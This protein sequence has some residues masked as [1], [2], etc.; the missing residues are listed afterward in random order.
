MPNLSVTTKTEFLK[1]KSEF[2]KLGWFKR[3]FFPG[4]LATS[5]NF[6][7]T[8]IETTE[9]GWHIWKTFQKPSWFQKWLFPFLDDFANNSL[10]SNLEKLKRLGKLSQDYFEVA[11]Q[12]SNP[13]TTVEALIYLEEQDLLSIYKRSAQTLRYTEANVKAKLMLIAQANEPLKIAN[14]FNKLYRSSI[15][16]FTGSDKEDNKKLLLGNDDNDCIVVAE[17]KFPEL[18]ASGLF[19]LYSNSLL[20][21]ENEI[22]SI[23]NREVI[24]NS[25]RPD[26]AANALVALKKATLLTGDNAQVNRNAVA[27]HVNPQDLANALIHLNKTNLLNDSN[28]DAVTAHAF[29]EEV[30]KGLCEFEKEGLLATDQAQDYR[31]LLVKQKSPNRIASALVILIKAGLASDNY[32][33]AVAKHDDCWSAAIT[34]KDLGKANLLIGEDAQANLNA[35][36]PRKTCYGVVWGL[37]LLNKANLLTG[38]NAQRFR[39]AISAH[40]SPADL[41]YSI[42]LLHD[43][44]LLNG[45]QTQQNLAAIGALNNP[46]DF[47]TLLNILFNTNPDQPGFDRL[48]GYG[49]LLCNN[50]EL[51]HFYRTLGIYLSIN[52]D[53]DAI[54]ALCENAQ[55]EDTAI[56]QRNIYNYFLRTALENM[57][58]EIRRAYEEPRAVNNAQN[59]HTASVHSTTDL[60]AWLL[61]TK[62]A[63][64]HINNSN[65]SLLPII[66]KI[67]LFKQ[68]SH[69][70][71]FTYKIDKA[72]ACLERLNEQFVHIKTSPE[73]KT[74][75]LRLIEETALAKNETVTNLLSQLRDDQNTD[76]KIPLNF[77]IECLFKEINSEGKADHMEAFI[78]AIYEIQRGY[79]LDENG[80]DNTVNNDD[81]PICFGGTANKFC[82]RLQGLSPLIQFIYVTEQTI[83][84]KVFQL[85]TNQA[86]AN[87]D[88]L[89]EMAKLG[90]V[91]KQSEF[92]KLMDDWGKN[93]TET[94]F[95]N[96]FNQVNSIIQSMP[97]ATIFKIVKGNEAFANILIAIKEY[98]IPSFPDINTD[99]K[100]Y[101]NDSKAKFQTLVDAKSEFMQNKISQQSANAQMLNTHGIYATDSTTSTLP[102]APSKN[103]AL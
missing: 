29:P 32:I 100:Y 88:S 48:V 77:F 56:V 92:M 11:A 40:S 79:N 85:I 74:V 87:A 14:A 90:D 69:S 1:L 94:I 26:K 18:A 60:T 22:D 17:H 36:L 44:N 7:S 42:K 15:Y 19:T 71:T 38:N 59:T 2:D 54:V 80:K 86:I 45:E 41:A 28:R 34:I 64:Q 47:M 96:A 57:L 6:N 37:D 20:S 62:Y 75:C 66:N 82:E 33:D 55:Q 78:N 52:P 73:K 13:E 31:D 98:L 65:I 101:N 4:E 103:P 89:L 61:L 9:Q 50:P 16:F 83:N 76:L 58:G 99:K 3:I 24:K 27:N 51:E 43:A 102:A 12:N 97:E 49:N 81:K 46:W 72:I 30:A 39:D 68:E 67:K 70:D 5:L 25:L 53:I 8:P 35:A 93:Q 10:T 21:C 23:A 91:E 84:L 63:D 95:S